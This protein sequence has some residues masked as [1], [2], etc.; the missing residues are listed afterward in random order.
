MQPSGAVPLPPADIRQRSG[1][2][3]SGLTAA[4]AL[5][6]AFRQ[7]L[8]VLLPNVRDAMGLT[9]VQA[10]S[11]TAIQEFAAG[12]IDL[13]G[14]V[15][16]DLLKRHWGLIMTLCTVAFGIGWLVIGLAPIYPVLLVGMAIVAAS[17]SLWHLPVTAA[18]SH[19]FAE[20]RGFALSVHNIGGNIGDIVGPAVTG[21]LLAALAWR[22][23]IT[24]YA[25]IPLLI[26]F[27]VFWAFRHIGRDNGEEEI[28]TTLPEQL[29][30]T[31]AML[32]NGS[33]WG[34]IIVA[35]LRGMAF[36]A[37]T[38]IIALY[39]KDVLDLSG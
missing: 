14:G 32:K 34:V 27:V 3:L 6:H 25:I 37:F 35:G 10:T 33:L 4:H 5:F 15:A 8:L 21:L 16:M 2:I 36:G 1:F 12:F 18:L 26:T 28:S 22:G 11:I 31:K 39:A 19:R 30:Y 9:D 29:T 38:A 7:S 17:S 24:I 23:I 13:P 20:R